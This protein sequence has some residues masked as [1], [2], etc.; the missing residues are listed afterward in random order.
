[1]TSFMTSPIFVSEQKEEVFERLEA[2]YLNMDTG[3]TKEK[4]IKVEEA[5]GR[6]PNLEKMP[7]DMEDFP[8]IVQ[9]AIQ[10]FNMLG[11]RVYSDVGYTGKDYTNLPYYIEIFGITDKE[12][13]LE[14]LAWLDARAI[15]KNSDKIKKE[16]EKLKSKK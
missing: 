15:K 11:D 9:A 4:Y 6:T 8:E 16:Y 7:P 14:V 12:F 2:M 5:L 3:M 13:F 10:T 1:M